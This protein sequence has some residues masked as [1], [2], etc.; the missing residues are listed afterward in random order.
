MSKNFLLKYHCLRKRNFV[1][2]CEMGRK[3]EYSEGSGEEG[4]YFVCGCGLGGRICRLIFLPMLQID[5]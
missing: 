5:E 1:C 2:V 3:G 4:R